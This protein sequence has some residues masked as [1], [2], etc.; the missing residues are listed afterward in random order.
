M[1]AEFIYVSSYPYTAVL[2]YVIV[3]T[4]PVPQKFC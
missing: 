4:S 1:K 2:L 3:N